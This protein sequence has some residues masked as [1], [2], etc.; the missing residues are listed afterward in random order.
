MPTVIGQDV[1]VKKRITHKKCGAIIEY[2]EN[3]VRTLYKG[4]DITGC[5]EVQKGFTC[6]QCGENVITL[7]Y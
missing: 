4:V 7:S 6:P 2:L 3:E 5:S 1:S